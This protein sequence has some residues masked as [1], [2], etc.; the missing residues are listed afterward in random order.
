MTL[1]YCLVLTQ[2]DKQL[3]KTA[4]KKASGILSLRMRIRGSSFDNF[5]KKLFQKYVNR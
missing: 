5:P 1:Y 2:H 3:V 4:K